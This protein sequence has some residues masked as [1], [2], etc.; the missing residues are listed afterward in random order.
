MSF[1]E[2][3]T[4]FIRIVNGNVEP[5]EVTSEQEQAYNA[6]EKAAE[7]IGQNNYRT[8]GPTKRD[9]KGNYKSGYYVTLE[10]KSVID[11][12][13][14]VLDGSMSPEQAMNLLYDPFVLKQRINQ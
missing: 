3:T 7:R 10:H 6:L 2:V 1:E 11:A 13:P 4:K 14:K 5:L 9:R 8:M 12:M